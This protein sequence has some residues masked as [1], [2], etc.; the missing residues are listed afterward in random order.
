MAVPYLSYLQLSTAWQ[1][2]LTLAKVRARRLDV[3]T[4]R[5]PYSSSWHLRQKASGLAGRKDQS[6][7]QDEKECSCSPYTKSCANQVTT[8]PCMGSC[9]GEHRAS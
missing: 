4:L 9:T 8:D 2:A 5:S 6:L 3:H 7:S 1:E